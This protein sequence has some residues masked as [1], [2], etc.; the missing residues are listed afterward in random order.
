MTARS[1]IVFRILFTTFEL[2][3][4]LEMTHLILAQHSDAARVTASL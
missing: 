4:G 1:L 3:N 2:F